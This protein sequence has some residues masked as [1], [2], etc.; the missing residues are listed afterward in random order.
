MTKGYL[1]IDDI[2]NELEKLVSYIYSE[3]ESHV[4]NDELDVTRVNRLAIE[5]VTI[6]RVKSILNEIVQNKVNRS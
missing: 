4:L 1:F 3:M 2:N 5:R 6:E